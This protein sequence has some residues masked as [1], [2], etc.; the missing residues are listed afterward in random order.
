[1]PVYI[2][3]I[4]LAVIAVISFAL[5]TRVQTVDGFFRGF[6]AN[7]SAP[8][9]WTL[10][11]SQVTTW[12]FA[13]SLMTAALLGYY[14]GIAGAL[15]YTAYYLS[16]FTGGWIIDHLRFKHKCGNVQEFMNE[17]F[18]V[19]GSACYNL[20]IAVRLLSEVFSNLI[21][22][23][24]IFG[25]SG[26]ADY[27][28]AILAVAVVTFS[29]SMFGGLHASLRTDVAQAV[30]VFFAL[31]L[32]FISML[33]HNDFSMHTILGSSADITSPGWVLLVV[34]LLQIWSYPLHDPVMMDRGFLAD[35]ETTKKSFRYAALI[36]M[37]CVF[38]FALLGV[39]SGTVKLANE[40]MISTLTRLFGE[41]TMIIFNIALIISAVSTLDSTFASASKLVAL[42]MGIIKPTA[43]NGRI[44][45]AAFLIG[46]GFFLLLG[47]KDLYA[48]VAVS[49]TVSMFLTPIILFSIWGE[50]EIALWPM[51]LTFITAVGGGLLYMLES[52]GYTNLLQPLFG[53]SHKYSKLLIICIIILA[54]G[55]ISFTM[56]KKHSMR[57]NGG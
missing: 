40:S 26:S 36:A 6:S 46:G 43:T 24:L 22:I 47:S 56:G 55:L 11:L 44:V 35:R 8:Q 32:L 38:A 50:R 14:Y 34:A 28:W 37:L 23:G 3:L 18:G 41:T 25:I 1:M 19:T 17:Q 39:F 12:I 49:G 10:V 4:T 13:R 5:S 42:D 16:F 57:P 21:V 2:F 48:A 9:L 15:A 45:M 29:Y 31:I 7:G 54:T 30:L 51:L 20:V 53:Y 33:F 27:F 52:S